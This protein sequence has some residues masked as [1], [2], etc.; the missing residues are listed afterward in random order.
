MKRVST[1]D[2]I[3]YIVNNIILFLM[4]AVCVYPLLYVIFASFSK[5]DKLMQF[6]GALLYPLGFDTGAYKEVLSNSMV[7]TSYLNTIIYV[8]FG[9]LT[10]LIMTILSAYIL[11][12]RGIKIK[13]LL[14]VLLIS[15]MFFSGGMI[16]TYITIKSYHMLNTIWAIILPP[17]IS[18]MNV[19]VMR[20][21]F[22]ALPPS[23]EEA[24]AID[25]ISEYQ[26]LVKMI[27][28]LSKSVL[29]VIALYYGVALWNSWFSAAIYL[30]KRSMYP[31]QLY[32]REVLINSSTDS[33]TT[34]VAEG[35]KVAVSETIKYA[36]IIVSTVPILC[37]YPFL[38]KY[39]VKGV[40]VGS[41]KG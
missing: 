1:G 33:M 2:K 30:D 19:I 20:T 37:V 10:A 38:Q 11:S 21:S 9:T 29:A 39:F 4:I 15:S 16:P 26:F 32:L 12:R 40:M 14:N 23:L 36:T 6:S 7:W 3:F 27:L 31:L 13:K 5:P 35:D 41:V 22:A 28:P 18:A 25:G 8:V 17:A 34:G 24:A